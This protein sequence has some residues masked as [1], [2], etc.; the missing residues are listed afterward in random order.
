MGGLARQSLGLLRSLLHPQCLGQ[1]LAHWPVKQA[2]EGAHANSIY[3]PSSRENEASAEAGRRCRC[4][5]CGARGM[6]WLSQINLILGDTYTP[7]YRYR[8]IYHIWMC[9]I[10]VVLEFRGAAIRKSVS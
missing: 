2:V 5:S 6:G 1:R 10:F 4:Q 9:S 7:R 8:Y 3:L